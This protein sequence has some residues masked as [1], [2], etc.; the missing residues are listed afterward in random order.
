MATSDYQNLIIFDINEFWDNSVSPDNKDS[1][2]YK[3]KITSKE[4][5]I[6]VLRNSENYEILNLCN[7]LFKN[8][9]LLKGE[10]LVDCGGLLL[11]NKRLY[12]SEGKELSIAIN[13]ITFYGIENSRLVIKYLT[14][15]GEKKYFPINPVLIEP[16]VN[17]CI[18]TH[19]YSSDLNDEIIRQFLSTP[20][21]NLT[22]LIH[23]SQ[24]LLV[25]VNYKTSYQL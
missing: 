6:R 21:T 18:E 13:E 5:A 11:T 10:Y 12:L 23:R 2:F 16:I 20:K 14:H 25:L 19:K 1:I 4:N 8:Y 22:E 7:N 3:L 24:F 15:E 9:Y 17:N